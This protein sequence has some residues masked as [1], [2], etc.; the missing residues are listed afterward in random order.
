[1]LSIFDQGP[2]KPCPAPFN[3]AGYVLAA[4]RKTPNKSALEVL[5]TDGPRIWTYGDITK[6]ILGIARGFQQMGLVSGDRIVLRLGNQPETPFAYLAAIAVDLI[7][8]PTS[9]QLTEIETT[10]IIDEI[11]PALILHEPGVSCPPH[12]NRIDISALATLESLPAA[13]IQMGDPNRPAYIVYTSGTSGHP[14]AVQH[15]HRAIWARRM[16]HHGWYD[17]KPDD[18]MLHAGAFNWTYTMGTGLMDPWTV[19]ATA[20]IPADGVGPEALPHLIEQNAPTIFAAAPGVYRKF[21]KTA[22]RITA[23]LLRHGLS[24]GEKLAPGI[25]KSWELATG[26]AVHEA[27]GMSECSTFVSASP[28]NPATDLATGYPQKGRKIAILGEDL[29]PAPRNTPGAIAVHRSDP[30]LMLGYLNADADTEDKFADDWFLTGDQGVMHTDGQITYLGRHDDMMNAG[31]Y[32]VSPLEVETAFTDAP[33]VT[34]MAVTQVQPKPD[35]YIIVGFYTADTPLTSEVLQQHAQARLA[36]YKCPRD[37]VYVNALP[38]GPNGK[39]V[40][41]SLQRLWRPS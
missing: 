6:A 24:A 11:D 25:R 37:Y 19:G 12:A 22:S 20:L 31:G 36:P 21:L 7:P 30:G 10:R 9:P 17:L 4:G 3:M 13:D 28:L 8:V 15:A 27:F 38:V 40:R 39:L 26:T 32:R 16:M 41:K 5:H 2:D 29:M 23:P 18:R 33:G 1:M 34:A 35:V 14:R